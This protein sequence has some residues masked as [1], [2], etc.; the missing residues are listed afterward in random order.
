MPTHDVKSNTFVIKKKS[1]NTG[2][3][4]NKVKFNNIATVSNK[5]H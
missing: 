5:S 3:I 1:T 4:E 2:L